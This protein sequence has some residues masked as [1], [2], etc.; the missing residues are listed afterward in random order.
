MS[1]FGI[2]L[3]E[4]SPCVAIFVKEPK[5]LYIYFWP[6]LA[7]EYDIEYTGKWSY[8]KWETIAKQVR[9][10]LHEPKSKGKKSKSLYLASSSDNEVNKSKSLLP[11]HILIPS[12]VFPTDMT[13]V[14]KAMN[15]LEKKRDDI[16]REQ[17]YDRVVTDILTIIDQ[18]IV[19]TDYEIGIEGYAFHEHSSSV[20]TMYELGGILRYQLWKAGYRYREI[21]PASVKMWF[22][23]NGS[24]DK[25]L[26][27][28]HLIAMGIIPDF[29]QVLR[30]PLTY[31]LPLD[32]PN[33]IQDIADAVAVLNFLL[34]ADQVDRVVIITKPTKKRATPTATKT[35]KRRKT[36]SG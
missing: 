17:R 7:R 22:T 30:Y 4:N 9:S 19:K 35:N 16:S 31:R 6:R 23:G 12:T 33:P 27:V 25:F 8:A 2:D 1:V 10:K 5:V 34:F 15:A 20:S 28:R 29:L 36:S 3:S 32:V 14:M 24:A 26:T 13:V 11:P 21:P 18:H